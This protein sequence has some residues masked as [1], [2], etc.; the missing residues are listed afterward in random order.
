MIMKTG[1]IL[2]F[3]LGLALIHS[4]WN[5]AM[6]AQDNFR[7]KATK[8]T[9][10]EP[11]QVPG[12]VLAPGEYIFRLND[13]DAYRHIVQIFNKDETK[14][15]TTILAIPNA[16][17]TPT[18]KGIMIYEERPIGQPVALEAWFYSG[19]TLGQ[20]FVYPKAKAEELS[21]LNQVEVPS[22][23]TEQAYPGG[24]AETPVA[25][26]DGSTS[27]QAPEPTYSA[28]AQ[29]PA[30]SQYGTTTTAA[31]ARQEEA[32]A[33]PTPAPAR[34][35]ANSY[36]SPDRSSQLPDTASLLPLIGLLGSLL[37][38]VNLLLRTIART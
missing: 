22:T 8:V 12:T 1:R 3:L 37:I 6:R 2:M 18:D 26:Q 34:Q 17:L 20:Q 27:F 38:G 30:T 28:S 5:Q 24:A 7:A 29:A 19:E 14:L 16:R 9:V 23:G 36:A 4:F 10:T 13:S 31:P 25:A 35:D 33:N 15:I 21:R 32:G 11:M